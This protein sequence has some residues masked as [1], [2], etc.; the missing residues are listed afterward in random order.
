ML[1]NYYAQEYDSSPK[2]IHFYHSS[3]WKYKI[4][5]RAFAKIA[6]KH[7]KNNDV[8]NIFELGSGFGFNL[9][10]L[11]K[12]FKNASIFSDDPD[13]KHHSNRVKTGKLNQRNYDIILLSHVLE[14][15][16]F[17]KKIIHE[18]IKSLSTNGLCIIE[19][20]NDNN[21]LLSKK[22]YDEPHITFFNCKSIEILF[23]NFLNEIDIIEI[24]SSGV[25]IDKKNNP[26]KSS[27]KRS[28]FFQSK[29]NIIKNIPSKN[30]FE[31]KIK[32]LTNKIPPS[33][34]DEEQGNVLRLI[35]RKK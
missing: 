26:S 10:E 13:K 12:I 35:F 28:N 14:H 19:V 3:Y 15:V 2:K 20:P 34:S 9:I 7:I 23:S 1:N 21:F 11:K 8:I 18:I 16:V 32:M 6:Q 24:Y 30:E 17:P 4:R 22:K 5:G 31:K 27:N 29:I 25:N 33:N